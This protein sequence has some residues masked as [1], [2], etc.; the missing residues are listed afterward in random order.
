MAEIESRDSSGYMF[1]S[2]EVMQR[3]D[4]QT[5]QS[6]SKEANNDDAKTAH[7]GSY[8]PHLDPA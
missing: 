5:H 8:A 4:A 3:S 7:P 6:T 2:E 1:P